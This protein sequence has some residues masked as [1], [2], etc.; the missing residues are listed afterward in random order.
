[1]FWCCIISILGCFH[2]HLSSRYQI[3]KHTLDD[4]YPAKVSD[5]GTSRLMTVDQTYMTTPV[6]DIFENLDLE[7]F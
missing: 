7:Y 1:M 3:Y 5:F 4:K 6:Q 2:T